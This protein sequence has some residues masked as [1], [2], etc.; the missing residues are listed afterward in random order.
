MATRASAQED[1]ESSTPLPETGR[2]RA[3]SL[4]QCDAEGVKGLGLTQLGRAEQA[5]VARG[6]G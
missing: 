1:V 5:K 3:A 2:K 4:A 6:D